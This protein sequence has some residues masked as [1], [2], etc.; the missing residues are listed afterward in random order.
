MKRSITLGI[1]SLITLMSYAQTS[2]DANR[3]RV[4]ISKREMTMVVVAPT[5]DTL[6][7]YNIACG[8]AYGNKRSDG[9]YRTPEG[10]FPIVSIED[11]SEWIYYTDDGRGVEDVYGDLFFRLKTPPHIGIGIHGTNAPKRIPGRFTKGCIRLRNSDLATFAT[12]VGVGTKVTI[13]PDRKK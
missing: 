6:A 3:N 12:L 2:D 13:L 10:T 7:C 1:V 8:A 9:D 11:S 5:G 4:I